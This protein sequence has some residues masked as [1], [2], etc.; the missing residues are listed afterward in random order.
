[1]TDKNGNGTFYC[2]R[3]FILMCSCDELSLLTRDK[4]YYNDTS[5]RFCTIEEILQ[6]FQIEKAVYIAQYDV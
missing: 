5:L 1:M 6:R 3:N 2:F 4:K